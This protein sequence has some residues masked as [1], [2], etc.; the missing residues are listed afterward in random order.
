MSIFIHEKVKYVHTFAIVMKENPDDSQMN[1]TIDIIK[2]LKK[3]FSSY[4]KNIILVVTYWKYSDVPTKRET[5][6]KNMEKRLERNI[7]AAIFYNPFQSRYR[8]EYENELN[9]FYKIPYFHNH[10]LHLFSKF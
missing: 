3:S 6:L 9:R 5:W 2:Y 4:D 7:S 10:R 1:Q 8:E